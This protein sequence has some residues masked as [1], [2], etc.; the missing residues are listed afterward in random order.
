MDFSAPPI[1]LL[2]EKIGFARLFD[3]IAPRESKRHFF[4]G[5]EIFDALIRAVRPRL[6]IEVGSWMG[7]SAI[8]MSKAVEREC[9]QT[10]IICVDT[11]LGSCEHYFRDDYLGDLAIKNGRPDFYSAFLSNLLFHHTEDQIIP[12]SLPSHTAQQV[13]ARLGIKAD[14]IYI[15]AGHGYQDV[16]SDITD[17]R[18][19]LADGGIMFGDDYFYKPLKRAVD[20]FAQA[21][22]LHVASYGERGHKWVMVGSIEEAKRV[23]PGLSPVSFV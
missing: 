10:P 11:W 20:D 22:G 12:V 3:G 15:D 7:H 14:I 17:Y 21:N 16:M 4:N 6:I 23:V 19:L 9:G 1:D 5:A 8:Y 2:K 13:L 18:M